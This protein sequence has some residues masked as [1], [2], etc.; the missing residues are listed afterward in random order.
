MQTR[1]LNNRSNGTTVRSSSFS[2]ILKQMMKLTKGGNLRVAN[3]SWD[4]YAKPINN[5]NYNNYS[6]GV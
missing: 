5:T 4:I 6:T 2:D 1:K 3:Q